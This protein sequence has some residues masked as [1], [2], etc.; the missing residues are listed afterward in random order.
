MACD[1]DRQLDQ[2]CIAELHETLRAAEEA[3][4]ALRE[5]CSKA[6]SRTTALETEVQSM[7]LLKQQLA[8]TQHGRY[9]SQAGAESY[10]PH[11]VQRHVQC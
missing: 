10:D 3:N 8:A 7:Q 4:Q 5:D 2:R 6:S 11:P 1:R 9:P